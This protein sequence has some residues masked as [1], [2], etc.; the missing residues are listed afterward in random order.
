MEALFDNGGDAQDESIPVDDNIT[1]DASGDE[2]GGAPSVPPHKARARAVS[3]SKNIALIAV[4]AAMVVGGKF[5][6][7]MI[8]NVEIVTLLL[9]LFTFVFGLVRGLSV[10]LIFCLLDMVLYPF[11]VDVAV[12]Y[13]NYWPFLVAITWILNNVGLKKEVKK[14]RSE[15][16]NAFVAAGCTVLFGVITSFFFSV[17]YGTPFVAVYIRG[18]IFYAIQ[19]VSNFILLLFL[20]K[21]LS[22]LLFK[23]KAVY[24][25]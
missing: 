6:L 16:I 10:A 19:T 9:M 2:V 5:A 25:F 3:A 15:Y 11:S 8:P 21:P 17:F 24:K 14:G 23:L 18:I 22:K 13:F 1:A 7:Q 20:F 12:A 4:L